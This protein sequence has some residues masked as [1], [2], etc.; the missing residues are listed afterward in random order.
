MARSLGQP[1]SLKGTLDTRQS[2][3]LIPTASSVGVP[4]ITLSFPNWLERLT[5]LTESGYTLSYDLLQGKKILKISQGKMCIGQW[6]GKYQIQSFWG[7]YP[8]QSGCLTFTFP[9]LMCGGTQAVF[10]M[11]AGY[12][13][14]T[15]QSFYG[16]SIMQVGLVDCPHGW[17]QSVCLLTQRSHPKSQ[18]LSG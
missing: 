2:S 7:P 5:Q 9:V 16:R 13:H 1:R 10:P 6:L 3:L 11:R 15:T 4:K 8:V 14:L 17:S 18:L 12:P